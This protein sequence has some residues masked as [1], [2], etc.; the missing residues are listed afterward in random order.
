MQKEQQLESGTYEI[1]QSRFGI[2]KDELIKRLGQLN[3]KRNEVFGSVESKL[4]ATERINTQNLC[5]ARDIYNHGNTSIFAYNVH[6]GLRSDIQLSDVFSQYEFD[7]NSF[8]EKPLQLINNEQFED[9]FK[10]LY[11]YYRNTFFAKFSKIGSY[12]YMVFQ[13]SESTTDIKTFKWLIHEEGLQYIDNRSDQ[14]FQYPNQHEFNW[15]DSN[16]DMHRHGAHPHVSILDKVFVETVGGDL[17]IK[18]EDNTDDGKGIYNEAVEY[19]DQVLEDAEIRFADLGNLIILSIKPYQ[20]EE[21]YFVYNHKVKRVEKIQSIQDA[22][23]LLPESQGLIF[24]DGYYLQTGAFKRFEKSIE[25]VRYQGLITSPNGED[26]LYVF[27]EEAKGD[28]VLMPYNIIKQDIS[29]P[30]FCNGFNLFPDGQLAY[31]KVD[32]EATKHHQIQLWSTPFSKEIAQDSQFSDSLLFKIGNKSLVS[33]MAECQELITLL[34]KDDSYDSLYDDIK[35]QAGEILD[36]YYWINETETADLS[37]P[38]QELQSIS[39]QAI[40]AFEKVN[41]QR[42]KAAEALNQL[43]LEVEEL[44]KDIGR[45]RFEDI[46]S[47]VKYLKKLRILQGK[48]IALEEDKY[49]DPAALEQLDIQLKDRYKQLSRR[50]IDFLLGE[51]A[52][53]PYYKYLDSASENLKQIDRALD[54]QDLIDRLDE[55]SIEMEMLIDIVNSLNIEDSNQSTQIIE[56]I[57]LLFSSI[58]KIRA[59]A[60]TSLEGLQKRESEADF[61]AQIKLLSQSITNLLDLSTDEEK[62]DQYLNKL[63]IQLEELEAK[64]AQ[65]DDFIDL[66]HEK[67]DTVYNAFDSKK[68]QLKAVRNAKIVRMEQSAERLLQGVFKKAESLKTEEEIHSF[69]AADFMIDKLRKLIESFRKTDEQAKAESFESRLKTSKEESLTKLKDKLDLYEDGDAVIR[70]GDYKFGVNKQALDF[71]I[72]NK[73]NELYAHLTGTDFYERIDDPILANAEDIWDQTLISENKE[74]YRSERLAYQAVNELKANGQDLL[75]YTLLESIIKRKTAEEFDAGYIKGVHDEDALKIGKA[76]LNL[77]HNLNSLKYNPQVRAY[78]QTFWFNTDDILRGSLDHQIKSSA[79]LI[80]L[81]PSD[82]NNRFAQNMLAKHIDPFIREWGLEGNAFDMA[83]YLIDELAEKNHFSISEEAY[84]MF[85]AFEEHLKTQRAYHVFK[86]NLEKVESPKD[87]F[88]ACLQWF[89]AFSNNFKLDTK[90]NAE[91]ACVFLYQEAGIKNRIIKASRHSSIEDLAGSHKLITTGTYKL[92]YHDFANRLSNF[93]SIVSPRFKVFQEEKKAFIKA[94]KDRIGLEQYQAKVLSSFVRNKLIDQVYFPLIGENLSKQLGTVGKDKRT[95]RMGM[96]LL[97]S[98]PGYGKTTLM[99]YLADRIGLVFMKINGPALGHNVVS[100]DPSTAD[101]AACKQELE[102]LNL[103]LE[104]GDNVMLYLDDIQHCNPEFLQKFISLAD[105]QRKIEGIYKGKTKTYD[106][107]DKKFCVVMA[108]NPYTESGEKF[109]IPDMLANRSDIYN[110]GDV[111]GDKA[112]LFKLSLLENALSSNPLLR[113]LST[114]S[115]EDVYHF[116]DYIE[117]GKT[118]DLNPK[119][120]YAD[121]ELNDYVSIIEKAIKIRNTVL[122]VNELYIR[123]A[124]MEDAYRTEPP[125]KLQGSYRDMNKLISK[126]LPIMNEE[127]LDRLI[128]THYENES[129]TLSSAAESNLLKFKELHGSMQS[130]EW[131]RWQNIKEVFVKNNKLNGLANQSEMATVIQQMMEFTDKLNAIKEVLSKKL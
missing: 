71:T 26:F 16:F 49:T 109:R 75:D 32:Q 36:S 118:I 92:D 77:E 87:R 45:N 67:R 125:F 88:I 95:D 42:K 24:P 21:R 99:E 104:M 114:K 101:N 1:I 56:Q 93:E 20:E 40:E 89:T 102:K 57:S 18:I 6:F 103:A 126:L 14:E 19:T 94:E 53:S 25:D 51:E 120:K 90:F 33:A 54:V 69:F 106:F 83:S 82:E 117:Q 46:D 4:I 91:A 30:I 22:A 12:L 8:K 111:I 85:S 28:Y 121:Q 124:A 58:N 96:L 60:K 76:Y 108:G 48:T 11:K 44:M 81:F 112:D 73:N 55:M 37:T 97:I 98:P 39:N 62:C 50:C 65:F 27:Y 31:F 105:G 29:T 70:L 116:I 72:I 74:V 129:Q 13:V 79:Q 100:L 127:E 86:S 3:S 107:K 80:G 7:G 2:Q 52:L 41:F 59:T 43:Q 128:F 35:K 38:L 131:E 10:N 123:S 61:H 66:I 23:I 15:I 130:D 68:T 84:D 17:T 119:G 115:M 34:N 63:S 78:A 64:F 9:D 47:Y 110:L 5:V 113:Q 122:K